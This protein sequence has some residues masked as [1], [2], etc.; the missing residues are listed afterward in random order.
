MRYHRFN[1]LSFGTLLVLLPAVA[2]GLI[3]WKAIVIW[4]AVHG[5]VLFT[6]AMVPQLAFF[7]TPIRKGL[8]PGLALTF[9]DGPVPDITPKVLDVLRMNGVKATF[10]CKGHLVDENPELAERIVDEGHIIANHTYWHCYSWGW[11][12]YDGARNEIMEGQRAIKRATGKLSLW[13]RPPFGI[14]NP[15]ISAAVRSMGLS[16]V[17]WDLR[18]LD[19]LAATPD[20]VMARLRPFVKGASILLLHDHLPHTPEVVQRVI[21]LCRHDGTEIVP[22]DALIESKP[23]A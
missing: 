15:H 3:S 16:V 20:Q 4:A 12:R 11:N 1:I 13:F 2:L 10:F 22:L 9:D 18:S 21:D 14:T 23:Y 8:R 19:T 17:A 6:G 5:S 7:L